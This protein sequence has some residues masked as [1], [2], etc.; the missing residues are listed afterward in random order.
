MAKKRKG[1]APE[2]PP[3]ETAQEAPGAPEGGQGVAPPPEDGTEAPGGL[4]ARMGGMP[5]PEEGEAETEFDEQQFDALN[6]AVTEAICGDTPDGELSSE[7]R[8]LLLQNA[9]AP[10]GAPEA[11]AETAAYIMNSAVGAAD[12]QGMVLEPNVI[13]YGTISTIDRLVIVAEGEAGEEMPPDEVGQAFMVGMEKLYDLLAPSGVFS[14]RDAR[15]VIEEIKRE[16]DQFD[17]L[18]REVA[19]DESIDLILKAVGSAAQ[20]ASVAPAPPQGVAPPPEPA[21]PGGGEEMA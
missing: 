3:P 14:E 2:A 13:L 4:M 16:P 10:H 9:D 11:I 15:G 6:E 18:A 5:Q 17:R 20:T 21:P 7:V 12:E 8:E 19:G 1:V